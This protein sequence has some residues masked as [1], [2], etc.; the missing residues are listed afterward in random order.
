MTK[1]ITE[2][3]RS[4]ISTVIAYYTPAAIEALP[5][6]GVGRYGQIKKRICATFSCFNGDYKV[7][8]EREF[9]AELE[10]K[11]GKLYTAYHISWCDC[12]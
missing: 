4:D 8:S 10:A 12:N 7:G 9:I 11:E 1:Q 3:Q 2:T 5:D 6:P